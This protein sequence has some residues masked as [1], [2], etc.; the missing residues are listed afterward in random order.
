MSKHK[1]I[2]ELSITSYRRLRNV[3][4]T[5][6][7]TINVFSGVNN[8]GKT[9]VL[10][11]IGIMS[12]VKNRYN[13]Q[14]W[15]LIRS[16]GASGDRKNIV[17]YMSGIFPNADNNMGDISAEIFIDEIKHSAVISGEKENVASSTGKLSKSL[18]VTVNDFNSKTL[19]PFIY[20]DGGKTNYKIEDTQLFN[21]AYVMVEEDFY[22]KSVTGFSNALLA[23]Q[24]DELIKLMHEFDKKIEDIFLDEAGDIYIQNTDTGV[25]PLF[26]YGSGMQK[27]FLLATV[28]SDD[29]LDVVMVDDI[30]SA[31]NITALKEVLNWFVHTCRSKN[32]QAFVTTHNA[33]AL[34]AILDNADKKKDDI[35][36]ITMRNQSNTGNTVVKSLK[37]SEARQYRTDYEME[38]RV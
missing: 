17:E 10:E 18:K 20:K 12:D 5:D 19:K 31:L 29:D 8:S 28:L 34:D 37:G 24:K 14:K 23:Q 16:P 13:I 30:D 2:N 22:S 25:L 3:K 7:Q 4:L 27:A 21:L 15:A 1:R 36:I 33:E 9:S 6:L 32:I 11:I 26:A 35:R 38:L